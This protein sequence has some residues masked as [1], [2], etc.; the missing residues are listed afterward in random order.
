MLS[1]NACRVLDNVG[2]YERLRPCGFNFNGFELT[3]SFG[4]YLGFANLG[5]KE[6]FGYQA[7]RLPREKVREVLLEEAETKG[8]NVLYEK[9][10]LDL[11]E[12]DGSVILRF[13]DGSE[14]K[15]KLVIGADGIWSKVRKYLDPCQPSY[16]GTVILYGMMSQDEVSS[17]LKNKTFSIPTVC[18]MV[19]KEGSFTIS[20]ADPAGRNADF[21]VYLDPSDRSEKEWKEFDADKDGLRRLIEQKFCQGTWPEEVEVLCRGVKDED[22]RTWV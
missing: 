15:S 11:E 10:L 9:K 20:P 2:V 8:V 16:L 14:T 1:A 21:F 12:K 22:L 18:M 17:R 6:V 3:N 4:S 13:A 5:S 7:M 19:G